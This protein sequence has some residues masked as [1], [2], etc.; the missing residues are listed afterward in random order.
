MSSNGQSAKVD[1]HLE[2]FQPNKG[3]FGNKM[4]ML[5]T[6]IMDVNESSSNVEEVGLDEV[7]LDQ[8]GEEEGASGVYILPFATL[9]V[10]TQYIYLTLRMLSFPDTARTRSGD[11]VLSPILPWYSLNNF[12]SSS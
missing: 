7:N 12:P 10:Y 6:W 11:V 3:N 1:L 4:A 8:V 5:S 2:D 9:T